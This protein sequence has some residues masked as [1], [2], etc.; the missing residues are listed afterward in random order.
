MYFP[1]LSD[2][3]LNFIGQLFDGNGKLK[4]WNEICFEF[5]LK[6][7]QKFFWLQIIHS[8]PKKWKETVLCDNGNAKNLV[9]YNYHLS[10]NCQI[11]CLSKLN[12]KE[13]YN[14]IINTK[15]QKPTAQAYFENEFN[16]T[17]F[18]WKKIYLLPRK[19]T[20][21][22]KLRNFQYKILNNILFLNKLLFRFKVVDS[23]VCSF[24]SW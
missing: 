23:S 17:N 21:D 5:G 6:N 18:E 22:T 7:L 15:P 2:Q 3:N 20:T 4:N 24:V 14:L 10:R 11:Y 1:R 12:C 16:E 13:L 19:V 9:F 8:I